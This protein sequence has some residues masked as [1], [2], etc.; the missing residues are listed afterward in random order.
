VVTTDLAMIEDPP[1]NFS[2]WTIFSIPAYPDT[3]KNPMDLVKKLNFLPIFP[4]FEF[5]SCIVN[6]DGIYV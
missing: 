1:A 3:S 4:I 6:N 2:V 5:K